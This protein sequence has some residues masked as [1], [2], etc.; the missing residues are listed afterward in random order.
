MP[1]LVR[2]RAL[3]KQPMRLAQ[4]LKALR[5]LGP[6][7]QR[8]TGQPQA[9]LLSRLQLV[10][11]MA[12]E[13]SQRRVPQQRLMQRWLQLP[14]S[15]LIMQRRW[16]QLLQRLMMRRALQR[17]FQRLQLCRATCSTRVRWA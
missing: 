2:S 3:L 16:L 9:Q 17:V 13:R 11:M 6:Q 15:R 7:L 10:S 8:Q 4:Q 14:S 1:C 5:L 12:Q